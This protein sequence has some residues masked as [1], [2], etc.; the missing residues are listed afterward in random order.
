MFLYC[1]SKKNP[2]ALLYSLL[3]FGLYSGATII[4]PINH[5][6]NQP[7][8][9]QRDASA[10]LQCKCPSLISFA[11]RRRVSQGARRAAL[12]TKNKSF[13]AALEWALQHSGDKDFGDPLPGYDD[14]DAG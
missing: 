14:D 13:D 4:Q 10:V 9:Q 7:T 11:R 1:S 8:N 2:A 5:S 3:K 6:T 12:K